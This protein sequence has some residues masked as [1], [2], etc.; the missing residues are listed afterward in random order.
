[1]DNAVDDEDHCVA[2]CPCPA[3]H[4]VR[5]SL[6]RSL[7]AIIPGAAIT[8]FGRLC[9]TIEFL[10]RHHHHRLK[11]KCV[12][13]LAGC[14]KEAH[15]CFKSPHVYAGAQPEFSFEGLDELDDYNSEGVFDAPDVVTNGSAAAA[16]DLD[17][18]EYASEL[19]E[20][21]SSHVAPV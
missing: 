3:L 11:H 4:S 18:D 9:D 12:F 2:V 19:E 8:S 13:F 21:E 7:R 6:L 20:I 16:A 15:K 5:Q 10:H 1:V 14:Y 17:D